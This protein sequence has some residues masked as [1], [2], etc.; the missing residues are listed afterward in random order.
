[1]KKSE[2]PNA[3]PDPFQ[4]LQDITQSCDVCHRFSEQPGRFRVSL[5]SDDIVFNRT[6]LMDLMNLSSKTV[7]HI[8]CK[9]TLFS[10][11]IFVLGESTLDDWNDYVKIWASPYVGR[12]KTIHADFGPQLWSEEWKEYSRM[13]TLNF[14]HR[15]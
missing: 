12:P 7:L 3:T 11:A 8:V 1:M 9:D 2:D 5:T 10:A 4:Q 14:T 6:L 13:S 15:E